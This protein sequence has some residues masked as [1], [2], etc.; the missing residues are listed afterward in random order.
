LLVKNKVG[1]FAYDRNARQCGKVKLLNY[2]DMEEAQVE[3]AHAQP[4]PEEAPKKR[5]EVARYLGPGEGLR[6][7]DCSSP[8]CFQSIARRIP[9]ERREKRYARRHVEAY[10][11]P[12]LAK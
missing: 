6:F 5:E 7:A 10:L 11:H 8:N 1:H 4:R 12:P 2:E 3:H 9:E